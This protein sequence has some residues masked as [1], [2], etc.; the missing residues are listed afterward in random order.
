MPI[1][2]GLETTKRIRDLG[3]PVVVIMLTA[4]KDLDMMK[5]SAFAGADDYITKPID[6]SELY[7]KILLAEKYLPFHKFRHSLI[8]SLFPRKSYLR[9]LL[10]N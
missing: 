7:A 2:N 6:L 5:K 3:Y 1:M 9:R 8:V 4:Y 10:K